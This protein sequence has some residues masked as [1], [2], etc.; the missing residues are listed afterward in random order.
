MSSFEIGATRGAGAIDA[1]ISPP[2]RTA[3]N[4]QGTASHAAA[5]AGVAVSAQ[6]L[7]AEQPPVDTNR[8]SEIRKAIETGDYP[9]LPQ[10]IGDAM[11]AAGM[12]LRTAA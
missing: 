8:V 3:P 7:D 10:E 9:L 11:I 1:R 5:D 12:L 6:A 2:Q 4:P